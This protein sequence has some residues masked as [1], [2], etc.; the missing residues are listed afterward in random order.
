MTDGNSALDAWCRR[1][2]TPVLAGR[3]VSLGDCL[4]QGQAVGGPLW[5]HEG[6]NDRQGDEPHEGLLAR[7]VDYAR[8]GVADGF[9]AALTGGFVPGLAAGGCTW[10]VRL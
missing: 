8:S 1:H 9:F 2:W 4:L 3:S 10:W 5:L 6:I 7:V